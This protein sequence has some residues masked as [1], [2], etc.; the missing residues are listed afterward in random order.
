MEEFF[1]DIEAVVTGDGGKL[2]DLEQVVG[3]KAQKLVV[4]SMELLEG[5]E[6]LN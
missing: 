1:R 4:S 6:F 5:F 3:F 2:W